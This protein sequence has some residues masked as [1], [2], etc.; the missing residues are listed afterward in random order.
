[1]VTHSHLYLLEFWHLAS[2]YFVARSHHAGSSGAATQS[3]VSAVAGSSEHVAAGFPL[4][5]VPFCWFDDVWVV[6]EEGGVVSGL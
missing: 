2:P 1:M 6:L 4:H 5:F 3:N